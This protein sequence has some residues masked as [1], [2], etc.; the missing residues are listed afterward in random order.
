[1]QNE[2]KTERHTYR[3][4]ERERERERNSQTERKGETERERETALCDVL[5][6]PGLQTSHQR[7]SFLK[8]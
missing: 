8:I 5:C 1:M 3:E 6:I 2:R 4:R 7:T